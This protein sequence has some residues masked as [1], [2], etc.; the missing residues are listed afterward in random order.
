MKATSNDRKKTIAAGS[1]GVVAFGCVIYACIQL[2][3]GSSAPAPTAPPVI[4]P[5]GGARCGLRLQR[6]ARCAGRQRSGC[7]R[8]EAGEHLFEP[9]PHTRS[10]GHAAHGEPG[11]LGHWP[12]HLLG[13]LYTASVADGRQQ[14]LCAPQ[15]QG[16]GASTR[17]AATPPTCPPTCPP[18]N[19]KFFGTAKH[20]N[21]L[22]QASFYRVRTSILRR[23][24]ISLD[25]SIR[26]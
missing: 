21:G 13:P 19:L 8:N 3:G 25:A 4:V 23:R 26:S 18:I 24:A 16:T 2:F 7:C 9:R 1:L 5:A 6:A 14:V 22:V 10:D 12:Q 20:A 15:Q 11:I 17:P